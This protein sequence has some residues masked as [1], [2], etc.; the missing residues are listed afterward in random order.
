MC[1]LVCRSLPSYKVTPFCI[2][3]VAFC[4]ERPLLKGGAAKYYFTK[5]VHLRFGLL[6]GVT[7]G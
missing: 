5:S 4:E 3:K 2:E 1:T 6:R 7:C